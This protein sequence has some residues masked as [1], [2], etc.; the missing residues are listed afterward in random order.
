M[1]S[2]RHTSHKGLMLGVVDGS[3]SDISFMRG[4][5]RKAGDEH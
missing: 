3:S 1:L 4:Q 5:G 2:C